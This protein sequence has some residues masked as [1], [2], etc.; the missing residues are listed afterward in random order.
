MG[1]N[2]F[3]PALAAIAGVY[4]WLLH[5]DTLPGA[6]QNALVAWLVKSPLVM[7]CDPH[8][9]KVDGLDDHRFDGYA[10]VRIYEQWFIPSSHQHDQSNEPVVVVLIVHGYGQHVGRYTHVAQFLNDHNI[11]AYGIDLRGFGRSQGRRRLISKWNDYIEDLDIAVGRVKAR[12]PLARIVLFGFSLGGNIITS[13]G[14]RNNSLVVNR[15]IT[16]FVLVGATLGWGDALPSAQK[17]VSQH[18][19]DFFSRRLDFLIPPQTPFVQ[20]NVNLN[21]RD[22]NYVSEFLSDPLTDYGISQHGYIVPV[23]EE[24]NWMS[25]NL[26]LWKHRVLIQCGAADR[27]S[28]PKSNVALY[29]KAISPSKVLKLYP[30]MNHDIYRETDNDQVFADLLLWIQGD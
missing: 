21:S 9:D 7:N 5:Q 27:L 26:H 15:G 4:L 16:G 2:W 30:D 18:V 20:F 29:E 24:I 3:V 22:P 25:E 8:V 10:G 6:Q 19:F 12:F 13:Y 17:S 1:V 23:S 28:S 14:L 11:Y